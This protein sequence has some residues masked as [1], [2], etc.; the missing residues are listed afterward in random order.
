MAEVLTSSAV[1]GLALMIFSAALLYSSVGHAGAS[2]YL[3][4]MA[5]F[6]LAPNVMKPTALTLNI[7]VA[8][9]A[10]VKFVR[11]GCFSWNL[12][13]PF[14]VT[15]IPFA[16]FGG[17]LALPAKTYKVIVGLVLLY[18]AVQLFRKTHRP[19]GALKPLPIP[20]A[21]LA[22]SGIGFLSGL[23]GVGGGIFLSP[24]LL[25]MGWA[26]TRQTSGVAVV[27]ILMNSIAGQL[28]HLSS[29]AHLPFEI[30]F[31]GIAAVAGGWIGA[32]LGSR[33]LEIP[34]IR[35]LL[36]V[37]LVIAGVKMIFY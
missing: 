1:I 13:W 9:I 33:R 34:R 37:V 29:V 5:L 17:W 35:Q 23:T 3:A 10:S 15:S 25:L 27:F 16:F 24:L 36:S 22:G 12:F 20:I 14:A 11:A 7:L 2:G 6:G 21:L 28:G 18:A 8:A 26:E 32:E 4:A 19:S 30:G 31:W